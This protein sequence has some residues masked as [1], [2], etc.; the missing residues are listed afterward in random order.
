VI[1]P[2][3]R[4]LLLAV[5]SALLLIGSMST[6]VF[7]DQRD[8]NINNNSDYVLAHAYVSATVDPDWGEDILGR[9]VLN[10]GEVWQVGFD[11]G[12]LNTCVWDVKVVTQEGYEV[13]Y[14]EVDLCT[15]TDVN[16]NN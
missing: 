5:T 9:E 1:A 15:V 12:D 4:R 13:K 10:P 14:P 7:A 11:R 16:V 6:A 8:F 3:A 2:R